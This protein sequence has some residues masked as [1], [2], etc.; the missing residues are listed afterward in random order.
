MTKG[1]SKACSH[2]TVM[3][4]PVEVFPKVSGLPEDRLLANRVVFI[5]QN[6]HLLHRDSMLDNVLNVAIGIIFRIPSHDGVD[7][8]LTDGAWNNGSVIH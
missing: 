6:L 2:T 4:L 7:H 1:L 5:Q 3:C 8:Y